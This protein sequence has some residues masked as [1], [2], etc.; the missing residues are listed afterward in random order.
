MT[1][2]TSYQ[3]RI[4]DR[5][6]AFVNC[7]TH[8]V[9]SCGP[10]EHY[11]FRR[12]PLLKPSSQPPSQTD[13]MSDTESVHSISST[14]STASLWVSVPA[15]Q[16]PSLPS[17]PQP[18]L[19]GEKAMTQEAME[20]DGETSEENT[21]GTQEDVQLT[22]AESTATPETEEPAVASSTQLVDTEATPTPPLAPLHNAGTAIAALLINILS[23]LDTG[24]P[25]PAL[26]QDTSRNRL[27]DLIPNVI[28][29]NRAANP[30][31]AVHKCHT[32]FAY[33][34]GFQNLT[35]PPASAPMKIWVCLSVDGHSEALKARQRQ[36]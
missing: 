1:C 35:I 11:I 29:A 30:P 4:W 10:C 24:N 12:L 19:E 25:P 33:W 9:D 14:A 27:L 13:N 34:S 23:P 32:S 31:E 15:P 8:A 16:S 17:S 18:A 22:E 6:V 21:P 3:G 28:E 5:W 7:L 20:V 26:S 36:G 2:E